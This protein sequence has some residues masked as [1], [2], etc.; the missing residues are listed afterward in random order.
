M[1]D[2]FICQERVTLVNERD[3]IMRVMGVSDD[4]LKLDTLIRSKMEEYSFRIEKL[5]AELKV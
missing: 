4:H 5:K 1:F 3:N 2:G